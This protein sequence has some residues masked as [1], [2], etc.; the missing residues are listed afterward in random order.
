MVSKNVVN[1]AEGKLEISTEKKSVVDVKTA[2]AS[3][4]ELEK[5]EEIV[6][7]ANVIREL[8]HSR[9]EDSVK[10]YLNNRIIQHCKD[11]NLT[12]LTISGITV[13][14]VKQKKVYVTSEK[15]SKFE[16]S[17]STLVKN[18]KTKLVSIMGGRKRIYK[19]DEDQLLLLF[20]GAKVTFKNVIQLKFK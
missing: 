5:I 14:I 6:F 20:A 17:K 12:E 19:E 9:N 2:C 7:A 11:N 4:F 3:L 18:I 10:D 15:I 13:S 16:K 8:N 1:I